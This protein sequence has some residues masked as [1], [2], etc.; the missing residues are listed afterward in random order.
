LQTTLKIKTRII[1]LPVLI[2]ILIPLISC[3]KEVSRSPVESEA[4]KGFIYISSTPSG[5]TIFQNG[6]NT[7]RLTPDSI[8]YIEA[9]IYEI[10]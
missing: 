6:R 9:G 3:D 2:Y 1:L 5:F 7:G 4:P 8:S 10:T